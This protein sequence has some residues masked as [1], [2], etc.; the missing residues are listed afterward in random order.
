ELLPV[1]DPHYQITLGE[2]ETPLIPAPRLGARLGLDKLFIK[3][4]GVNPTGSFKARGMAVAVSRAM[5]LG[6]K[7][8]VAPTAG[9]AGGAMAAYAAYAGLEAH[10]FMP[11]DAPLLNQIEAQLYGAQLILVNGLIHDAARQAAAEAAKYGWF[12]VTTLKE[13]YR[14]EGKKTM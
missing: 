8:L 4:E 1:R 10:V 5:E 2:G 6:A 7:A 13:P 12:D 3:D 11:Q 14:I 9:N